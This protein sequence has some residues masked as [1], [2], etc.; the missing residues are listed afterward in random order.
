MDYDI[1]MIDAVDNDGYL[2]LH[3]LSLV[4]ASMCPRG[5]LPFYTSSVMDWSHWQYRLVIYFNQ[6]TN[7]LYAIGYGKK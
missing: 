4:R 7:W 6:S 1:M 3:C 2:T 5:K